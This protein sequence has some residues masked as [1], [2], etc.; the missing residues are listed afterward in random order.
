MT[1]IEHEPVLTHDMSGLPLHWVHEIS[2]PRG[3][4]CER[5][6]WR[7][8]HGWRDKNGSAWDVYSS[9]FPLEPQTLTS[10]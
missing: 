8:V 5:E 4:T 3:H 9:C 1:T 2:I 7:Y 10:R 6:G